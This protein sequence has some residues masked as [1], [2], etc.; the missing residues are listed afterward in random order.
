MIYL[1]GTH[2]LQ[3][4]NPSCRLEKSKRFFS[5]HLTLTTCPAT[6]KRRP[7]DRHAPS[8]SRP[9]SLSIAP[10]PYLVHNPQRSRRSYETNKSLQSCFTGTAN[11]CP[12]N[13][14][15]G[16]ICFRICHRAQ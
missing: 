1:A 15:G 10:E 13:P 4:Q 11:D 16:S 14:Y 6:P 8:L 12:G 3:T 5:Q 2:S 9:N 7:I